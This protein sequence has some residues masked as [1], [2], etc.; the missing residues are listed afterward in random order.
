MAT[1]LVTGANGQL[2]RD[3]VTGFEGRGHRVL[4]LTRAQVDLTDGPALQAAIEASGADVVINSAA[5]TAVDKAET[6]PHTAWA[7]NAFAPGFIAKGCAKIGAR[8]VQISTDYVFNGRQGRPW[9]EWDN[10]DPQSI[11]GQSKCAGEAQAQRFNPATY[12]VRTSWVLGQYGNNFAKT[13]ITL[14]RSRDALSVVDDQSGAPTFTV[15]LVDRIAAILETDH[16]GIWHGTN[17]GVCTWFELARRIFALQGISIDL[18]PTTTKAFN[19]PAPRPANSVLDNLVAR[20]LG[21][22]AMPAWEES[23]ARFLPLMV[24]ELDT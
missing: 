16:Y 23:L 9:H 15:D 14:A 11:Y 20:Q 12:V 22:P 5:Y 4:P 24:E 8:L 21:L 2:G 13:M 3:L 1:I 7:V 18:S 6:D 10:T 19:A 17:A